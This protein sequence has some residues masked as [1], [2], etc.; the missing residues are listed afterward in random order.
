MIWRVGSISLKKCYFHAY[1]TI[2]RFVFHLSYIVRDVH[3]FNFEKLTCELK[4]I[5]K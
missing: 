4:R 3:Y 5:F 1:V 2:E